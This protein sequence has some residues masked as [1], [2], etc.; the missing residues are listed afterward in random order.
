[1][2][3]ELICILYV[4]FRLSIL[5]DPLSGTITSKDLLPYPD[6]EKNNICFPDGTIL[7]KKKTP[8]LSEYVSI[9]EF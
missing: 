9:L 1:M 8:S 2:A 5:T 3:I 6:L 4:S 7:L